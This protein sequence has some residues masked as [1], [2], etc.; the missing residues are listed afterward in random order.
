MRIKIVLGSWLLAIT[1]VLP[2]A[3]RTTVPDGMNLP[4]EITRRQA[5]ETADCRVEDATP[6][7][8]DR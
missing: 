3:D 4:A 2:Q 1:A 5:A 6:A 7:Q 8:A